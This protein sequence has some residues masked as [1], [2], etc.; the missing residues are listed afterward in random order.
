[1]ARFLDGTATLPQ[2]LAEYG[3]I[4]PALWEQLAAQPARN[5]QLIATDS[6]LGVGRFVATWEV[7]HG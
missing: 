3:V 5:K 1:M 4:E 7:D 6:S 2:D